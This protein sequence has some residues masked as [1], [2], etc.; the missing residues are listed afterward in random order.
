[1]YLE[2]ESDSEQHTGSTADPE[3][4]E[5]E[6][7]SASGLHDEHLVKNNSVPS[8][9]VQSKKLKPGTYSSDGH[10]D[11]DC[12]C[13]HGDILDVILLD[14]CRAVYAVGIV[15]DLADREGNA[16]WLTM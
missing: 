5:E 12:T 13:S 1:M 11:I 6:Q 7:P 10:E 2:V 16:L 8:L 14:S 4:T 3:A 9:K 15:V